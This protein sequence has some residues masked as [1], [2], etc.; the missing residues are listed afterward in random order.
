MKDRITTLEKRV[1]S[2]INVLQAANYKPE[3]TTTINNKKGKKPQVIVEDN[4]LPLYQS[5]PSPSTPRQT[6]TEQN[7]Y[8]GQCMAITKKGTRCKRTTRSNGYCW[9]HGG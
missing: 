6:V 2:L 7:S 8:S 3:K 5:S 1:D 4:S 9:Q